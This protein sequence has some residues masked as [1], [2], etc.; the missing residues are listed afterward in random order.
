MQGKTSRR[1]ERYVGRTETQKE[2]AR[3]RKTK[4]WRELKEKVTERYDG[5]DPVTLS[6]LRKGWNLHH[7]DLRKEN[8][9]DLNPEKFLPL[10][11][12]T[13]EAIHWLYSYWVKDDK[14]MQRLELVMQIMLRA[15]GGN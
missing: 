14:I 8:Y 6:P 1:P 5:L 2:K 15:N 10:N 12:R 4:A 9:A 11:E 3:V 7:C 13:H